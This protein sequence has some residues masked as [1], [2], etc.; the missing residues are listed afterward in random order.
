MHDDIGGGFAAVE[1]L[2]LVCVGV[3]RH[4]LDGMQ[5]VY[6]GDHAD[7]AGVFVRGVRFAAALCANVYSLSM[8]V[9]SRA[10]VAHAPVCDT[11]SFVLGHARLLEVPFT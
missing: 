6:T 10:D 4:W 1:Q 11:V 2:K 5:S 7:G 8:N 3:G 9:F